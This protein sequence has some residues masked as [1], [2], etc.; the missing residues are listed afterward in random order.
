LINISYEVWFIDWSLYFE[1][2]KEWLEK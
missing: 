1:D 2:V